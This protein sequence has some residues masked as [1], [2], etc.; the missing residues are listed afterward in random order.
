MASRRP[1]PARVQGQYDPTIPRFYILL[2]DVT[3]PGAGAD[4]RLLLRAM[5]DA[6]GP[7]RC[8]L[9]QLNSLP[10]GAP[11]AGQ[12]NIWSSHLVQYFA[13]ALPASP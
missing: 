1:P 10:D 4:P 13:G 11:A 6:H 9:L 12:P 5:H 8:H 2:H 7:A 3:G